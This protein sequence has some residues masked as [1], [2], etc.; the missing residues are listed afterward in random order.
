MPRLL[1]A[2]MPAIADYHMVKNFNAHYLPGFHQLLC[3]IDIFPARCW[4]ARWVI[5]CHNNVSCRLDQGGAKH[6]S[7]VDN[8][9][10]ERTNGYGILPYHLVLGIQAQFHKMFLL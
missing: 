3:D 9:R 5:V 1:H 2:E 8:I 7:W 6:L 4:V 10:I